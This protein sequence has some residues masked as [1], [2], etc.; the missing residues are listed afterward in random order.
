MPNFTKTAPEDPQQAL[1]EGIAL[2][3]AYAKSRA[4]IS[5]K[6][7]CYQYIVKILR[8]DD[9]ISTDDVTSLQE[10]CW[11]TTDPGL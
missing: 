8:K 7:D 6:P 11:C 3:A 4:R 10:N 1:F 5:G 9:S 2:A